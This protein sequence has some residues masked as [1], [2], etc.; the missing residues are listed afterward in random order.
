[1]I[2]Q[3]KNLIVR[4]FRN[5]SVLIPG[6]G[7]N[8]ELTQSVTEVQKRLCAT[9]VTILSLKLEEIISFRKFTKKKFSSEQAFWMRIFCS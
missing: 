2:K 4:I 6:S 3:T 7:K 9:D 8:K 5:Y 1:M